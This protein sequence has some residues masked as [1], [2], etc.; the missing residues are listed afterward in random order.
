MSETVILND[1]EIDGKNG[2]GGNR[3]NVFRKKKPRTCFRTA[4]GNL[5]S[6]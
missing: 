1:N 6:Y 5:K 3:E 2:L 4:R